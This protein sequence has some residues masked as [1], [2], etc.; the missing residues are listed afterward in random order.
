ME[1]SDPDQNGTAQKINCIIF[2]IQRCFIRISVHTKCQIWYENSTL[3][4]T[5]ACH[6][7]EPEYQR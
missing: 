3:L 7:S 5:Y 1:Q 2:V 4:N 6:V